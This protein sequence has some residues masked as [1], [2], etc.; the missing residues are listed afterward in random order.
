MC[1][2]IGR[3]G[4]GR[5]RLSGISGLSD[6]K[7]DYTAG[8]QSMEYRSEYYPKFRDKIRDNDLK[9]LEFKT[10]I[11]NTVETLPTK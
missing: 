10:F 5:D 2:V 8:E 1:E 9:T 7:V 11:D 6:S 4:Q 3:Q